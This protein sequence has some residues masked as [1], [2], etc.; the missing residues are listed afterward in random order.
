MDSVFHQYILG[1]QAHF[2]YWNQKDIMSFLVRAC[3]EK[4]VPIVEDQD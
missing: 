1:M 3:I 2:S 4:K